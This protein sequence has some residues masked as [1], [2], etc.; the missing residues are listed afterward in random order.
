MT[1]DLWDDKSMA[2]EELCVNCVCVADAGLC[3][4]A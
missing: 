2:S 3:W 1:N 4:F